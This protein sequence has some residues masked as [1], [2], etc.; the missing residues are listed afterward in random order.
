MESIGQT[1]DAATINTNIFI[2]RFAIKS[3]LTLQRI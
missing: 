3:S 2:F 1:I